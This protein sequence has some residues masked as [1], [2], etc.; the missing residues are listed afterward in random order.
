MRWLSCVLS[1]GIFIFVMLTASCR[2]DRLPRNNDRVMKDVQYTTFKV[3]C[4]GGYLDCGNQVFWQ[5]NQML[6]SW[7]VANIRRSSQGDFKIVVSRDGG[8][9]YSDL[10]YSGTT[11]IVDNGLNPQI[12]TCGVSVDIS[13]YHGQDIQFEIQALSGSTVKQRCQSTAVHVP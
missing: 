7:D 3:R 9:T 8:A 10:V 5:T 12:D 4:P 1:V 6:I 11:S 2:R 13:P